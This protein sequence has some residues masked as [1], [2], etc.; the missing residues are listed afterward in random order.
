MEASYPDQSSLAA[1]LFHEMGAAVPYSY[2]L[3]EKAK[4]LYQALPT[5][6]KRLLKIISLCGEPS[7]PKQLYLAAKAYSWLGS[8]YRTQTVQYASA[9]LDTSGWQELPHKN[10]MEHG[11]MISQEAMCRAEITGA[12]AQAQDG[13]GQYE[14]A[15]SNYMGAYRLEPY[16]A[17]HVIK[18]ADVVAKSRTRKE[19]LNFLRQQRAS[20]YYKPLKYKDAQG[21]VG[22]N[23]TFQQLIDAHILKLEQADAPKS[24]W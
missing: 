15:L 20:G 1:A 16:N 19:A 17:M 2:E 12:L 11:I 18:A 5:E 21:S 7:T 3:E 9:Y 23:D 10:L 8:Q 22:Y 6:E 13:L 4:E 14:A 24:S